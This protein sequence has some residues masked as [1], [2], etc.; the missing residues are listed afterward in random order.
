MAFEKGKS[1]NPGGL[2]KAAREMVRRGRELAAP[3][4]ESSV[5]KLVELR[6]T[7]AD[8]KV[9]LAAALALIERCVGKPKSPFEDQDLETRAD[10]NSARTE[11]IAVSVNKAGDLEELAQ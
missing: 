8:P 4:L 2:S 9:A 11:E 10:Y 3:H 6:D 7:C 1:G 5:A